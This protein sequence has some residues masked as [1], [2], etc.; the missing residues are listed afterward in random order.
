MKIRINGDAGRPTPMDIKANNNRM[1][2]P[3]DP[4][5][6]D[7]ADLI[8]QIRE[9]SI[10]SHFIGHTKPILDLVTTGQQLIIALCLSIL[11]PI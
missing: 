8:N 7:M 11:H 5:H 3:W 1:H 10:F 9:A 6:Q 2:A 4:V